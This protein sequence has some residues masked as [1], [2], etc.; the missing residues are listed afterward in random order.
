MN[1][2]YGY[3]MA[4]VWADQTGLIFKIFLMD[5]EFFYTCDKF[6]LYRLDQ[7]QMLLQIQ[8]VTSVN[9]GQWGDIDK[10]LN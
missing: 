10:M 6:Q 5:S 1:I 9:L 4:C 8:N 7:K 2:K 3:I